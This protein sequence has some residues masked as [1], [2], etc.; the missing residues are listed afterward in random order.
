MLDQSEFTHGAWRTTLS[1][2][3]T[4]T[5]ARSTRTGVHHPAQDERAFTGPLGTCAP[6]APPTTC[7]SEAEG[8]LEG[9]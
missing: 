2:K 5:S 4:V 6:L 8:V 3:T 1:M 9:A 7:C